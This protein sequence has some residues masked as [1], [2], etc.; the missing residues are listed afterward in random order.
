[1]GSGVLGVGGL[2]VL[3]RLADFH[4]VIDRAMAASGRVAATTKASLSGECIGSSQGAVRTA[5][6][7]HDSNFLDKLKSL[8]NVSIRSSFGFLNRETLPP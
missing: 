5:L 1:M 6:V 3:C 2:Q 7:R 8:N 4:E